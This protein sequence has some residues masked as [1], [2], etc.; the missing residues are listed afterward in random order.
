[1]FQAGSE[2]GDNESIASPRVSVVMPAYNDLRFIDAAV[3]SVL[4][5]TYTDFELIIV[6]DGTN[7][8]EVFSRLAA[9]DPRVRV[10]TCGQNNGNAAAANRGIAESRGEIIARLDA[11]DIAEPHRLTR[12]I[13]LL[14]SDSDLG[15]VGS[16]ARWISEEGEPLEL[17]RCPL[18]D[19]DIR[20][21]IL[22]HTPICHP[23]SAYR[24]GCFDRAGGYNP[25]MR[26]SGDHD[27]WWRMLDTC[28][29]Q[30]IP[31]PLVR[32]RRN[33]RG[34]SASNPP[35]WRE[36]TELLRRRAWTRLGVDYNA[37]LIPH[38]SVFI[39]GG[40]VSC[41]KLR[42][43]AYRAVLELLDRFLTVQ[44]LLRDEDFAG[45]RQLKSL[46]VG[47]ILAD[48]A[49]G[50]ADCVQ[51]L[52]LCLKISPIATLRGL[53]KSLVSRFVKLFR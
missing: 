20:W 12:L 36:R 24:R 34:L 28:R 2:C 6:D 1:M 44:P 29:A 38:L 19:L 42:M 14:D 15:L 32:Y 31:E 43:P 4:R 52:P 11:D 51:L 9:L 39:S 47:R 45:A 18:T 30:N 41:P 25:A 27:L 37:D 22:F 26:Q 35:N 48:R 16:W 53:A 3:M 49:I 50:F 23:S 17:W 21:T 7:R 33:S 8:P 40:T 10:I 13:A 5:Q 46:I